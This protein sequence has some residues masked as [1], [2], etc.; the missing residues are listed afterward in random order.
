MIVDKVRPWLTRLYP[1]AWRERYAVEFEALLEE[2]LHSPLDIVDVFLGAMDARLQLLNG[3]N[4][5]WRLMNMLNKLR[6][7][8][9][10]VFA[11]YIGFIVAGFSLVGLADDSPMVPLMKTKPTLAAAWTTIQVG[12]VVAL[13]AVVIGGLPLALTV[14]R[15]AL[16]P[17]RG[18][19]GPGRGGQGPGRGGQGPGRGGLGLL[20]VPVFAFLALALY[21]SFMGVIASSWIHIPGVLPSVQPDNF[22]AGNRLLLA[23]LMLVFVLG[24]IASTLAVWKVV[25]R[26]DV[27]QETFQAAGRTLTVKIYTFAFV[28]AVIATLAMLVMLAGTLAWG[29][30]AFSALPDVFSGNYGLWQTST[31]AWYFGI[32]ALMS[33]C[34]LAALFGLARGRSARAAL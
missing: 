7:T 5:T 4:V 14:L 21:V 22:P 32:V 10:I 13:L 20:L 33:V 31:Q 29:W 23:G 19:Q 3:E 24:A 26:T 15:R 9:L 16:A 6:T 17:N 34:S 27:E 25:S 28:P 8:L 30:L 2:C 1:R 18:G 12:S 11:A